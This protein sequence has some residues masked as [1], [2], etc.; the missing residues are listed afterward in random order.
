[1]PGAY[2]QV[3]PTRDTIQK[4]RLACRGI[5][6][7]FYVNE[8]LHCTVMYA[9]KSMPGSDFLVEKSEHLC[10]M[11]PFPALPERVDV[12]T[13]HKGKKI[14]VLRIRSSALTARHEF[15]VQQGLQP[16]F[17]IYNAHVTLT[18]DIENPEHLRTLDSSVAL[19]NAMLDKDSELTFRM[20]QMEETSPKYARQEERKRP[21]ETVLAEFGKGATRKAPK[22]KVGQSKP[23]F[24]GVPPVDN[25]GPLAPPPPTK[26]K[27]EP[28]EEEAIE[29]FGFNVDSDERLLKNLV[30][31]FMQEGDD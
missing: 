22:S 18:E 23:K 5:D 10:E 12:W 2:V 28:E 15:W 16:S 21:N 29:K 7:P 14:V 17:P 19:I 20:E 13:N 8:E 4:I 1:M 27:L 25:L 6:L 26:I 3:I 30:P 9:P 11:G 31:D 24:P